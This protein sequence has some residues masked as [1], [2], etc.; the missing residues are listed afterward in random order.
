MGDTKANELV[1]ALR[2]AAQLIQDEGDVPA[3]ALVVVL[4]DGDVR[5]TTHAADAFGI[6]MLL[7]GMEIAESDLR[8]QWR[9]WR[10]AQA[11]ASQQRAIARPT[12]ADVAAASKTRKN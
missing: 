6:H 2:K 5:T 9:T 3:L 4:P 8:A 7:G 10:T 1:T 11:A 12:L